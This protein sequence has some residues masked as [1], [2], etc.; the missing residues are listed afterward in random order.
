MHGEIRNIHKILVRKPE[1][2]SQL[3]R[4]RCRCEDGIK[5]DLTEIGWEDMDWTDLK[6]SKNQWQACVDM[7]MKLTGKAQEIFD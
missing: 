6:W 4:L 7:L 2:K 1:G 5:M 3:V